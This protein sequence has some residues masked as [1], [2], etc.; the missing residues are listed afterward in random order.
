MSQRSYLHGG[1]SCAQSCAPSST[2]SRCKRRCHFSLFLV[3]MIFA[4][5]PPVVTPQGSELVEMPNDPASQ[6]FTSDYEMD[7]TVPSAGYDEEVQLISTYAGRRATPQFFQRM[8]DFSST[9][10]ALLYLSV[11]LC[12]S[13]MLCG[14]SLLAHRKAITM[15]SLFQDEDHP[16]VE[17]IT[18]FFKGLHTSLWYT[19]L[20]AIFTGF[21]GSW[22]VFQRPSPGFYLYATVCIAVSLNCFGLCLMN[23]HG[24]MRDREVNLSE[25]LSQW[26]VRSN[27]TRCSVESTLMCSG[28]THCCLLKSL[29]DDDFVPSEDYCLFRLPNGTIVDRSRQRMSA[30]SLSECHVREG[31]SN[32]TDDGSCPLRAQGAVQPPCGDKVV[33]VIT[34]GYHFI[35]VSQFSVATLALLAAGFT[36]AA[37]WEYRLES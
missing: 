3:A 31:L 23:A 33:G 10:V 14:V 28:W 34:L 13:G 21:M 25:I 32:S 12:T 27:D 36:L 18:V 15:L 1:V 8:H 19:A 16:D 30:V 9:Q 29:T 2:V 7:W 35:V 6:H 24:G 4:S 37:H 22:L 11:V 20:P 26:W 17:A 5:K